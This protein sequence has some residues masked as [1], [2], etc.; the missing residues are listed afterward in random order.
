M[1]PRMQSDPSDLW[2]SR[3]DGYP[4]AQLRRVLWIA[5]LAVA[6]LSAFFTR[7]TIAGDGLSYIDI[8]E[9]YWRGEAKAALVSHWSPLYSWLLGGL[10]KLFHPSA[11]SE[12][13]VVH[14]LNFLIF[15]AAL[16]SF[17]FLLRDVYSYV[18]RD[19]SPAGGTLPEW[20]WYV[21]G[22]SL[23]LWVSTGML[24][25][26]QVSP[27]LLV[28]CFVYNAARLL[29]RIR[30]ADDR[31][32]TFATLGAVVGV[33]YLAKGY[34]IVMSLV[35]IGVAAL[36]PRWASRRVTGCVVA[37]VALALIAGPYI[38]ALSIKY[39]RLTASD[40]GKLNYLFQVNKLP[41]YISQTPGAPTGRHPLHQIFTSPAVYEFAT[42]IAGHY[43]LWFD[44]GYWVE[45]IEPH[46]DLKA[47][48]RLEIRSAWQ[49]FEIIWGL[50]GVLAPITMLY[51][52]AGGGRAALRRIL[53]EWFL[54]V[55]ALIAL[56]IFGGLVVEAR[57]IA[58]H[59]LLL[60]IALLVGIRLPATD[61]GYKLA[62]FSAVII[63]AF[64]AGRIAHVTFVYA[65][66][67]MSGN[68]PA[69][70]ADAL[71]RAGVAA[72]SDVAIINIDNYFPWART[73]GVR[74]ISEISP[75]QTDTLWASDRAVRRQVYNAIQRAGG[76]AAIA[77]SV[78]VPCR[79]D[80]WEPAGNTGL[81]VLRL[82]AVH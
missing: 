69:Q 31:L 38:A 75:A 68:V 6:A 81:W 44:P 80:G 82:S 58:P 77:P 17:E 25:V 9:L 56:A 34:F 2:I 60:W 41:W 7:N 64:L 1:T 57:Y 65:H 42:P 46:L 74:I 19:R 50:G 51:L 11:S 20:V 54:F 78:P 28:S 43:P 3:L 67:A 23:F 26:A 22:Y 39:G 33:G 59:M 29:V 40:S 37:L 48:A 27:D 70:Q 71:H 63:A 15:C 49:Y 61:T 66:E 32:R 4:I 30:A 8:A 18:K 72:G 76:A 79:S 55:P 10:M 12:Y 5:C 21:I 52:Y 14:F 16:V 13:A 24:T 36:L 45:G 53:A 73:A 62:A 35:I 47:Q